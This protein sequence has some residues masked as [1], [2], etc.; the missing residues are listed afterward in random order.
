MAKIWRLVVFL[1]SL[2][3][4]GFSGFAIIAA[5][6]RPEPLE[7]I[8]FALAT[9]SNRII[10]GVVAI[11]LLVIALLTLISSF[12]VETKPASIS[13]QKTLVGEVTITVAAIKVI[14]LKAIKKIEGI[15]E[16]K[17]S[18]SSNAQGLIVNLHIMID[19]ELSVPETSKKI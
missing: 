7:Y 16:V 11:G 19:P 8:N 10:L 17:T 18:V 12:K 9:P 3:L 5:I 4:L 1:Y 13:V 14:I 15:K 2:L 6:G